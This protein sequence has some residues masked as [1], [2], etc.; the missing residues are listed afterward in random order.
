MMKLHEIASCF[1]LINLCLVIMTWIFGKSIRTYEDLVGIMIQSL[2]LFVNL[3][4]EKQAK[5]FDIEKMIDVLSIHLI[6]LWL[7]SVVYLLDWNE[8]WQVWPKPS[9]GILILTTAC[10]FVYRNLTLL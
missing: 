9:I 7:V 4:F 8:A 1:T 10:N 5:P 3:A 2:L 6:G